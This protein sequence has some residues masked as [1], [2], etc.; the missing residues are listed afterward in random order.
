MSI[1]AD[2]R[3]IETI[4]HGVDPIS[5]VYSGSDLVWSAGPP[6]LK[7]DLGWERARTKPLKIMFLGSSTTDGYGT[8]LNESY[9][10]QVASL[11]TKHVVGAPATAPVK[12][13]TGTVTERTA[14]GF[15]FL[16]AGVGGTTTSTYCDPTR[17]KLLSG[18]KPDIAFH[19][20]GSND[21][22]Q[23][24]PLSTVKGNIRSVIRSI[25]SRTNGRCQNVFIHSY[26]R[27]DRADTGIT[28]AQYGEAI[29][30][31]TEEFENCH[32]L[33]ANAWWEHL[34]G[35]E[36]ALQNDKIHALWTGNW[37]LARAVAAGLRLDNHNDELIWGF[38]ATSWTH[39]S[40][41]T[42]M[43]SFQPLSGSLVTTSM[44][45]SGVKRPIYR[46]WGSGAIGELDFQGGEKLM[47]TVAWPGVHSFPIT[48][49]IV[50]RAIGNGGT[51]S[52]PF[53]TR[54]VAADDGYV[55]AWR[56]R[57]PN[58][59]KGASNSAFNDGV[60]LS[61]S[62]TGQPMIIAITYLASGHIGYYVNS[63]IPQSTVPDRPTES[64]APWMRSLK[65][66]TNTGNN[67]WSDMVVR[68]MHWHHG[69]TASNIH[70]RIRELANKHG[71][72]ITTRASD[73]FETTSA[74]SL[75]PTVPDW[76]DTVEFVAVGGGGGGAGGGLL[77]TGDGGRAGSWGHD[78]AK[79]S[80]G[81]ILTMIPGR[82]GSGGS[83]NASNGSPGGDAIVRVGK[84][85]VLRASGGGPGTSTNAN[86]PGGGAGDHAA[87]GR[88]FSGGAEAA[89][90]TAGNPPGGGGGPGA[91]LN[92]GNIG[93]Q[94]R[95][96]WRFVSSR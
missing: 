52:Q 80:G 22:A 2:G 17:G 91:Q 81:E 25:D 28:W 55:W 5:E 4:F 41:E 64:N 84:K 95:V 32:F 47:E 94:G 73:W 16:N 19:M 56:E 23:Q 38:D 85:E 53:F 31:V 11:M 65:I 69:D 92:F 33:D 1:T 18:W 51:A 44:R 82:G 45:S 21:Y 9:V 58:L 57:G 29:R 86:L 76:A 49:Y 20:I 59:L 83:K 62:N 78:T 89:V 88:T 36:G 42:P 75:T 6:T 87:F 15:H 96:W 39:L 24:V 72:E 63:L 46:A 35:G 13:N 71:I 37:L 68:E 70:S 61:S 74:A 3:S 48:V 77:S 66:G 90:G 43:S 67:A 34:G 26:R 14:T 10:T 40:N 93:G 30:E 8:T 54:S 79:V 12:Q 7:A 50:T 27:M 60:S